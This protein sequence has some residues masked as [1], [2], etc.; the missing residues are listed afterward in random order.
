MQRLIAGMDDMGNESGEWIMY[1]LPEDDP[2]CIHTFAE[3]TEL[4]SRV[5]FLPLFRNE[6]EGFSVE[7]H[8]NPHFWWS[9]I[10][11]RDPW[12]W[13]KDAARSGEMVYGKFFGGKA[14]MISLEWIPLF[15]S[16]RRNGYEFEDLWYEGKI[17]HREKKIMDCLSGVPE[18][19][20]WML[21][22]E[23]GFGRGGEKNFEGSITSLQDLLFVII[24][25]FRPRKNKYGIDYGWDVSVY[26][27]PEERFG[28]EV[29][30]EFRRLSPE[31]SR[32]EISEQ[33]NSLYPHMTPAQF[34]RLIA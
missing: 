17:R 8:V 22:R 4:I 24:S 27:R 11:E 30:R 20:G 28:E 3:L 34:T 32:A 7:E 26:S 9:G 21:K 23:A 19:P 14:G 10:P 6:I 29:F 15:M 31:R 2:D 5:G 16:V 13:R 33:M 18:M 25:D 1:G 12:E